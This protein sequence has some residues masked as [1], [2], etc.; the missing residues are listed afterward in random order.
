MSASAASPSPSFSAAPGHGLLHDAVP[1]HPQNGEEVRRLSRRQNG[2]RPRPVTPPPTSCIVP[3]CA[4]PLCSTRRFSALIFAKDKRNWEPRGHPRTRLPSVFPRKFR[5]LFSTFLE[6][7]TDSDTLSHTNTNQ[8]A[9]FCFLLEP[10]KVGAHSLQRKA[11]FPTWH[12]SFV[13]LFLIVPVFLQ[14]WLLTLQ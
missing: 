8:R 9:S 10:R 1:P 12:A 6:Q 2:L 13:L 3:G 14:E 4:A 7:M 5:L 11:T